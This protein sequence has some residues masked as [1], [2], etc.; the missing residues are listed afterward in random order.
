MRAWLVCKPSEAGG[1]SLEHAKELTL[2][3][4][5]AADD[6]LYIKTIIE[7]LSGLGVDVEALMRIASTF[8]QKTVGEPG[9][10]A[11]VKFMKE[12]SDTAHESAEDLT[13]IVENE[14]WDDLRQKW[15]EASARQGHLVTMAKLCKAL[16]ETYAAFTKQTKL[17]L[18]AKFVPGA[19]VPDVSDARARIDASQLYLARLQAARLV[20][21]IL[22]DKKT[23]GEVAASIR[24]FMKAT[25]KQNVRVG[26]NIKAWLE[27]TRD[28][29]TE[30]SGPIQGNP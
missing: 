24:E 7:D 14:Q 25:E 26:D 28:S 15:Q 22:P 8:L 5:K 11:V 30:P 23:K 18:T 2:T 10:A 1:V 19:D 27:T 9:V 6:T 29:W 4:R 21:K 17:F 3:L 20:Y 13:N 16:D 12:Q